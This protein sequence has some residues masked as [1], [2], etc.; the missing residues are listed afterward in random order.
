M[1]PPPRVIATIGLHS[2]ASTW[3]FNAVRELMIAT[4]GEPQIFS[5]FTDNLEGIPSEAGRHLIVK[6]HQPSP[7][8]ISWL[9]AAQAQIILSIRDPRDASL[10]MAQRFNAPLI[11]AAAWLRVDCERMLALAVP[12]MPVLRYEDRFFEDESALATLAQ[13]LDL[14]L[15]PPLRSAIFARYSSAAVRAFAQTLPS[16]PP[17]RLAT[18]WS[19]DMDRVTQILAPHIGDTKSG[20]W[21]SLAP[22]TQAIMTDIF[23]PFLTRFGY[24]P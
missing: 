23:T 8:L 3:V 24:P 11:K 7:E 21:R 4:H 17:E 10:S 5:L 22:E 19:F 9:T 2:S 15:A 20:K 18:V 16:L 12:S 14:P 6:S 1:A 13:T